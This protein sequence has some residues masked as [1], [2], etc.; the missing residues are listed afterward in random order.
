[1]ITFC[2][3][4]DNIMTAFTWM[5][6]FQMLPSICVLTQNLYFYTWKFIMS[7]ELYFD[8]VYILEIRISLDIQ[9]LFS[10]V[11]I[12]IV[13]LLFIVKWIIVKDQRKTK[14]PS[15]LDSARHFKI[16]ESNGRY[17]VKTSPYSSELLQIESTLSTFHK[18]RLLP[19]QCKIKY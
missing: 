4:C 1:M 2:D 10:S 14:G 15:F 7:Y 6:Q 11:I 13:D 19:E 18:T 8:A 12:T 17:L 16:T 3:E 9:G 5:T